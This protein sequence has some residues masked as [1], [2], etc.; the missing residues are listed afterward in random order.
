MLLMCRRGE[1]VALIVTSHVNHSKVIP[2]DLGLKMDA[3]KFGVFHKLPLA[4][5]IFA[6]ARDLAR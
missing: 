4:H 6:K 5:S 1:E 3:A 2:L